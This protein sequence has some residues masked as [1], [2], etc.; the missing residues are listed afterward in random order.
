MDSK[1]FF[2]FSGYTLV[3]RSLD[4]IPL[5]KKYVINTISPNSY[6]ISARDGEMDNALKNSDYLTLDGV[7]FGWLPLIKFG[8]RLKRITGWDSF[9]HFSARMQQRKGRVFFLGSSAETLQKIKSR[10]KTDYPDVET[11]CYS[12]PYKS[13]FS[14]EDNKA[15]H[16]AVNAFAPDVLFVGLTAPKQEKWSVG[17][18]DFLNVHIIA[19]IGNVFDW[20]AGNQKRP[21]IF[22]QKIGME[23]LIRILYRPE[24]FRRNIRN[25]MIFFSHLFIM[26]FTRKENIKLPID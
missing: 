25:Q 9:R 16:E 12:P 24:V 22:W 7:Y 5:D 3:V 23:W 2:K 1:D 6:G 14:Q 19:T 18:K 15:M 21:G 11:G 17:N 20:Y 10:Y 8:Q 4:F 26:L 13:E